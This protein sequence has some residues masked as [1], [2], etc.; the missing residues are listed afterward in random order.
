LCNIL[1]KLNG[2][3]GSDD[4]S[5]VSTVLPCVAK[6][7]SDLSNILDEASKCSEDDSDNSIEALE[8]ALLSGN[9]IPVKALAE[10]SN[11]MYEKVICDIPFLLMDDKRKLIPSKSLSKFRYTICE[12][13]ARY[14]SYHSARGQIW[15][16]NFVIRHA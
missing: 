9:D 8:I 2:L 10:L 1:Q 14:I 5:I 12:I 13:L 7:L 16:I 6:R 3:D 15:L 11:P 4:D